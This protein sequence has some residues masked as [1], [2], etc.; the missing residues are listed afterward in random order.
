M[1]NT[2]TAVDSL[3]VVLR[4]ICPAHRSAVLAHPQWID[5]MQDR[6]PSR[7]LVWMVEQRLLTYDEL[8]DLQTLDREPSERDRIVEEAYALLAQSATFANCGLLHQLCP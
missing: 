7:Q 3:P 4:L 6:D 8:D 2:C 1:A 5:V